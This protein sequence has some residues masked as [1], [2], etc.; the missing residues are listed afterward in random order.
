[1]IKISILKKLLK[2]KIKVYFIAQWKQGYI[3]FIDVVNQMKADENIDVRVLAFPEKIS[4]FP[5]NEDFYFWYDLFGYVTINS[6]SDGKWFDL[7]KE[8]PEYV[9]IQR[10]YNNYL[11]EQFATH[12][13]CNYTKLCYI[14]YAYTL[15]DLRSVGLPDDFLKTL[16]FHFAENRGEY[17]YVKDKMITFSGKHYS[18][19]LGYPQLDSELKKIKEPPSAFLKTRNKDEMKVI[20]TPRWTIDENLFKSTF[21]EFKDKIIKYFQKNKH[22]KLVFRPHP[23]M[24]DNYIETNLMTKKEVNDYKKQMK[25]NIVYDD[26]GDYFQTFR[27]ADVLITDYSSIILDFFILEKPIIICGNNDTEKY[28]E[29]MNLIEKV[30]YVASSWEEVVDYLEKLH[31]GIDSK[32]QERKNALDIIKDQNDGEVCKKII[33]VIKNDYFN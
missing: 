7:E 8:K 17:E 11:P 12:V 29:T 10:P 14:P 9:F 27:D 2:K 25:D 6:I 31:K 5:N 32:K 30:S 15:S 24:F 13:L 3:K 21:F 19:N 22:L 16:Y 23:L 26:Q 28:T 18:L 20:Y 33:D 4:A 1:M